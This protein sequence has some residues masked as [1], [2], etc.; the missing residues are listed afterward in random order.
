[1]TPAELAAE[2]EE[3]A[4]ARVAD[5]HLWRE[6]IPEAARALREFAE[7][8]AGAERV[9]GADVVVAAEDTMIPL[10]AC[11]RMHFG[12]CRE[13]VCALALPPRDGA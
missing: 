1:M 6:L 4:R 3:Y 9:P 7:I 10:P 8:K 13:L 5:G 12:P 11:G 2:L